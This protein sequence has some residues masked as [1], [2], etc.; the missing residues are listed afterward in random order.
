MDAEEAMERLMEGN[1]RF[2]QGVRK[3]YDFIARRKELLEGQ[4]PFAT[5]LTCSDS[6]V[7]PEYIFDANI[8]EI[9]NIET[10]GNVVDAVALGSIEYGVEHLHTPVLMI[11]GHTKCGAVTSCCQLEGELAGNLGDIMKKIEPA[12]LKSQKKIDETI[13]ENMKCVKEC[14]LQNSPVVKKAAEEGKVRIVLAKYILET[15]EV[16][17]LE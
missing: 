10:A 1:A 17:V 8:G 2:V 4:N 9:F 15:G 6:R 13:D 14:I 12:A 7:R 3:Q 5:I 11:L 16:K